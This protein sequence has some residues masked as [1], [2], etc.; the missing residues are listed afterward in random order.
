LSDK[1]KMTMRWRGRR[2]GK[3]GYRRR[4]IIG[5]VVVEMGVGVPA[6]ELKQCHWRCNVWKGNKRIRERK[7]TVGVQRKEQI[8]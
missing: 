5:L 2:R 7:E 3:K 8:N 1:P 4:R 6:I